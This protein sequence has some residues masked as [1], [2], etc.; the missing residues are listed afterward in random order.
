MNNINF[1]QIT[2]YFSQDS[3]RLILLIVVVFT[4]LI[5]IVSRTLR[6]TGLWLLVLTFFVDRIIK[7]LPI[8]LYLIYP[9]LNYIIY[10]FYLIGMFIF[11]YKVLSK[12][13]RKDKN[14]D[15]IYEKEEIDDSKELVS[16]DKNKRKESN[17]RK[18]FKFT[19]S[20]PLLIMILVNMV[21]NYLDIFPKNLISSL[22]SLSFLLMAFISLVNSYKYIDK[23]DLGDEFDRAKFKNLRNSLKKK[24]KAIDNKNDNEGRKILNTDENREVRKSEDLKRHTR[25]IEDENSSKENSNISKD[26]IFSKDV[27][28]NDLS[29]T[30]L[31]SLVTRDFDFPKNKTV[32]SLTSLEDGTVISH[33]S[34]SCI[35]RIVEDREYKV[36]LE[37]KSFNEYDYG[38]FIDLLIEY[39]KNKKSYKFKLELIPNEDRGSKIVFYDPSDIFD[40]FKVFEGSFQ[41][42]NISMNFPK[43]KINFVTGN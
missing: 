9:R 22:T 37:F 43:Y 2:Q 17:I 6:K 15:K 28:K 30:D 10:A 40:D 3:L 42:K 14:N 16:D 24:E 19:G 23:K 25:K 12:I 13:F 31:I 39:S 38:K 21:N 34:N 33:T 11:V 4:I 32:L 20:L 27:E 1:N 5:F 29:N 41:G 26:E 7:I 18:F 36:D 8:D 35:A